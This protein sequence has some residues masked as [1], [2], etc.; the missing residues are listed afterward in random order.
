MLPGRFWLAPRPQK[1]LYKLL[2]LPGLDVRPNG[3]TGF[4][5]EQ[6]SPDA[7]LCCSQQT[8]QRQDHKTRNLGSYR[9]YQVDVADRHL[10]ASLVVFRTS[11]QQRQTQAAT[12][13]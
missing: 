9:S 10:T 5:E 11:G 2:L 6:N 13:L 8:P 1:D 4:A 7:S 3:V 12:F